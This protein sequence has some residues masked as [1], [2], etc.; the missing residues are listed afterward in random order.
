MPGSGMSSCRTPRDVVNKMPTPRFGV[1]PILIPPSM[2]KGEAVSESVK[3]R[4]VP[5]RGP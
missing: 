5:D 4:F 1:L 3:R 2:D